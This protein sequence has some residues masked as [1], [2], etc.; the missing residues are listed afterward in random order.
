MEHQKRRPA[1]QLFSSKA[2][3]R[4]IRV[5]SEVL[6]N[7]KKVKMQT[8]SELKKNKTPPATAEV[9]FLKTLTEGQIVY[10]LS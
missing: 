4:R 5:E 6:L 8:G 2:P 3:R 10:Q 9:F 7:E 1:G